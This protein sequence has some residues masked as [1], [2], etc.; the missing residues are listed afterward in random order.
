M[1]EEEKG[2]HLAQDGDDATDRSVF[3]GGEAEN[4]RVSGGVLRGLVGV[5]EGW[6]C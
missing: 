1:G 6:N 4:I 2:A 5:G 3:G